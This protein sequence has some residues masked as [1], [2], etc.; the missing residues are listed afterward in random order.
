MAEKV[1]LKGW[2]NAQLA[3]Y[4]TAAYVTI[5]CI[6]SK[7]EDNNAR[8]TERV[9]VCTEGETETSIEGIDRTVSFDAEATDANSYDEYETLFNLKL[10]VKFRTYRGDTV[11]KYF[12]GVIMSLSNTSTAGEGVTFSSTININGEYTDVD[13]NI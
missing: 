13:P 11:A 4:K 12:T 7:T 10:P 5:A 9:N 8:T 3:Y 6:K 1:Y 2:K